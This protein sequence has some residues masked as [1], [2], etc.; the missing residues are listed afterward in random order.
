MY[1]SYH[2][3]GRAHQAQ[4]Y[5]AQSNAPSTLSFGIGGGVFLATLATCL[6][7]AFTEHLDNLVLPPFFMSCLLA[8]AHLS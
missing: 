5:G 6:L 3:V 8:V 4:G 7:E 2:F 1:Y